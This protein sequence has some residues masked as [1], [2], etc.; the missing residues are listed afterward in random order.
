MTR[1][2]QD[3]VLARSPYCYP[4]C[5]DSRMVANKI[6]ERRIEEIDTEIRGIERKI[7][8]GAKHKSALESRRKELLIMRNDFKQ[9]I[10]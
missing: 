5:P 7:A 8:N 2:D 6:I 10:D 3:T 4:S 1:I 9:L